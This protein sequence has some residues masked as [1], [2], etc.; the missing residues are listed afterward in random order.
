MKNQYGF[1]P[2]Q[3]RQPDRYRMIFNGWCAIYRH[4]QTSVEYHLQLL[5][6]PWARSMSDAPHIEVL[7]QD[8]DCRRPVSQRL[9]TIKAAVEVLG[10]L[11]DKA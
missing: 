1:V 11:F 10:K 8:K 3:Y 6:K 5:P 7:R 9:T 4:P 2:K